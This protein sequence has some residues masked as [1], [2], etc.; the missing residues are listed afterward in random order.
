MFFDNRTTTLERAVLQNSVQSKRSSIW[1]PFRLQKGQKGKEAFTGH[2]L[3]RIITKCCSR[4][5]PKSKVT[6]M[7]EVLIGFLKQAPH[8]PGG[9]KYKKPVRK[10]QT[11]SQE[12]LESEQINLF[13][14][15]LIL[16]ILVLSILFFCCC[17]VNVQR[18]DESAH[19]LSSL[20]SW[21][22]YW[23]DAHLSWNETEYNGVSSFHMKASTVW[24][25]DISI[26]NAVEDQWLDWED[27]ILQ[28]WSSGDVM[29]I[30]IRKIDTICEV[31]VLAYPFD[32]QKCN[33]ELEGWIHNIE[34]IILKPEGKGYTYSYYKHNS[35]WELRSMST[36]PYNKT[37]LGTGYSRLQWTIIMVRRWPYHILIVFFL[38]LLVM[39]LNMM[40]FIIP[41]DSGEKLGY[42]VDLFLTLI[43]CLSFI[44]EIMPSTSEN[45][46]YI[47]ILIAYQVFTSALITATSCLVVYI[48]KMGEK[49]DKIEN[50][51][52]LE[53]KNKKR[54]IESEIK[55]A[56][57]KVNRHL[58]KLQND[59]MKELIAV[60]QKERSKIQK[61]ITTSVQKFRDINVNSDQCDLFI[62][63]RKDRQA[64]IIVALPTRKIE[65]LTMTLQT[66]I[67]I[68][69]TNVRGCSVLP[70]CMMVF[71]CYFKDIIIVF[72]SDR[73]KD[74]EIN[75]FGSTFNMVFIGDDSIAV[76]SGESDQINVI[77]LKKR[78]VCKTIKVHS[79][80]YGVVYKDG[81]LIYCAEEKDY[82]CLV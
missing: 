47:T 31:N 78:K 28:V 19:T 18:F 34:N 53:N 27:D 30:P 23:K 15:T 38:F 9:P 33:I 49:D 46:P 22:I 48:I 80:N 39:I 37:V 67:S 21:D 63:K 75:K 81:H 7:E 45:I 70:D 29:W 59:L 41:D 1:C 56:R 69:L 73:S 72:Q 52:S 51:T 5:F 71:S 3:C 60:E 64:Q 35:A 11:I 61:Q 13:K 77:N 58:D 32:I 82:R 65:N 76:T 4:V 25:P 62:H 54:E 10:G 40:S 14:I 8:K 79:N 20:V 57:T 26:I 68:E 6:D 43:V 44:S 42:C 50:L 12:E 66:R 55:Q 36:F 17:K 24:M 74:F 2:P 16:L